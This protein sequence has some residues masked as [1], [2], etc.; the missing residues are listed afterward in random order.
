VLSGFRILQAKLGTLT[1]DLIPDMMQ[2]QPIMIFY[3]TNAASLM[4][5]SQIL[6]SSGIESL[7]LFQKTSTF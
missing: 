7:L 5:Y 1:I 6:A 3:K 4:L 2:H